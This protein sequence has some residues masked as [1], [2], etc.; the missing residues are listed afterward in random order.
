VVGGTL[1]HQGDGGG[2][3]HCDWAELWRALGAAASRLA[4][5]AATHRPRVLQLAAQLVNLLNLCLLQVRACTGRMH[6]GSW[7]LAC[8]GSLQVV[9]VVY[10]LAAC[11]PGGHDDAPEME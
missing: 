10:Q 2:R 8:S 7:Q 3:L 5:S 6:V 4:T 9:C 11:P 1:L